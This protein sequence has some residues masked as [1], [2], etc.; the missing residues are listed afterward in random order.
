MICC[1]SDFY[2]TCMKFVRTDTFVA[3]MKAQQKAV[4][5]RVISCAGSFQRIGQICVY[6]VL[7]ALIYLLN[8][9]HLDGTISHTV[10]MMVLHSVGRRY[11]ST[12]CHCF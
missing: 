9:Q 1:N 3:A 4:V 5:K 11:F 12:K 8:P 10:Q 2:H 7:A 6:I